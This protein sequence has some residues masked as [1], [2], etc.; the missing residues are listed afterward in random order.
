V[1]DYHK[2]DIAPPDRGASLIAC[3]LRDKCRRRKKIPR[4]AWRTKGAIPSGKSD[5]REPCEGE[6]CVLCRAAKM[7]EGLAEAYRSART[8]SGNGVEL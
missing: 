6:S 5:P 8:R 4:P 1:K 7:I 3:E 2:G